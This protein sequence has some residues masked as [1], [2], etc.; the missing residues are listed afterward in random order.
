MD[1][2]SERY[3]HGD[4]LGVSRSESFNFLAM[5]SDAEELRQVGPMTAERSLLQSGAAQPTITLEQLNSTYHGDK[6]P[7][8]LPASLTSLPNWC[9]SACP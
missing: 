4:V 2:E 9:S 5:A 6:V 3:V 8:T 1:E 7:V